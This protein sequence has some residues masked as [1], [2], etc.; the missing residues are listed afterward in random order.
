MPIRFERKPFH[1]VPDLAEPQFKKIRDRLRD[2]SS[3][4]G[5]L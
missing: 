4:I 5:K 1:P 2:K 3:L